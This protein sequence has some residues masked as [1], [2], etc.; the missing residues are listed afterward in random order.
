MA[1]SCKVACLD[2]DFYDYPILNDPNVFLEN[3][4]GFKKKVFGETVGTEE[5]V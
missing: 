1:G 4:F 5:S 3:P 2:T